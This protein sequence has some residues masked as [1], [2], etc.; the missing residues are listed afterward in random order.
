MRIDIRC[1]RTTL[2]DW[3]SS[4]LDSL[5][6]RCS[7]MARPDMAGTPTDHVD[8]AHVWDG[9]VRLLRRNRDGSAWIP[10][11]LR[12]YALGLLEESGQQYALVDHRAEPDPDP[13][14]LDKYK[15]PIPL[16]PHQKA[17]AD[18]LCEM[19]DA[20]ADMPPR[21]GKTRTLLEVVRRKGLRT[22]WVAPRRSIVTQTV[23]SAE[24]FF[25]ASDVGVVRASDAAEQTEKLLTICTAQSIARLP[26]EFWQSRQML[27]CD[28]AHHYLGSTGWG[29]TMA[30]QAKHIAH[31]KGMSGTFFRSGDDELA[32][33][34]FLSKV[35]FRI[36]SSELEASGHLVP[37]YSVFLEVAGPKV[38]A[39]RGATYFAPNGHGT[40]GIST[41]DA[42]NDLV[43]YAAQ[44]LMTTGRTVLVLVGTKAQG[45][46]LRERLESVAG[47][48][49]PMCAHAPVEF[50]STDRRPHQVAKVLDAFRQRQGV[51]IL[52]GT[53]MVGEGTDLP[54]AD[55]LVYAAGGQAAVT[56][57]QAWYRVITA[58][59]EKQYAVI[60][61]FADL[62]HRKLAE[63]SRTRWQTMRK[64]S[65]FRPSFAQSV[66]QFD[67]WCQNLK[68]WSKVSGHEI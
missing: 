65:I 56:L 17:C 55:A 60:V 51:R 20:V 40:L 1:S 63:H 3:S 9:R 21:A 45:Y 59:E 10:T 42:R 19:F 57:V 5:G 62:H 34:A 32:M 43:A 68:P 28:E 7:Y 23:K 14:F 6:E 53:S 47:P 18:Q 41:H 64:D 46:A 35:A 33:H 27:V 25:E 52:I 49:H 31:R 36:S 2:S 8:R 12:D 11:G 4:L 24:E 48:R 67:L 22:L 66:E 38:R 54:V 29:K 13:Y 44:K 16:W 37:A 50:V 39:G 58:T 61:D 15:K 30:E 26:S